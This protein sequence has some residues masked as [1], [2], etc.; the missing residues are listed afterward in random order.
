MNLNDFWKQVKRN[1]IGVFTVLAYFA[2]LIYSPSLVFSGIIE[3]SSYLLEMVEIL[4]AVFIITGLVE[5]WVP[6]ETIINTFG[7]GAGLKGKF[8]SVFIGS[9]SAGP[10]YAA[11]PVTFTLLK[12]GSSVSNVVIIL[13]AWAVIKAPMLIVESQFMGFSFMFTRYIFTI[14]AVMLIGI[15]T[16]KLVSK[17]HI[18]YVS[19]KS[20]GI[21]DRVVERLPGFNCGSCGYISCQKAAKAI[22]NEEVKSDVCCHTTEDASEG[23][24]AF[25]EKREPK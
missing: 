15:V 16:E 18:F 4:P 5:I 1:K 19:Q 24:E 14:P 8:I 23:V 3:T 13:S 22:I 10:I 11:F 9:F 25:L 20:E 6:K 17:E 2:V 7:K 12:K 21:I